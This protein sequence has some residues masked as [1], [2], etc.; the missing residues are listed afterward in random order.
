MYRS[1]RWARTTRGRAYLLRAGHMAIWSMWNQMFLF[2]SSVLGPSLRLP[3]HV[4]LHSSA[5]L[6]WPA[7]ALL[8]LSSAVRPLIFHHVPILTAFLIDAELDRAE[9]RPGSFLHSLVFYVVF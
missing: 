1:L 7:G 8:I 3:L 4:Y 2:H 6:A 5:T 9:F